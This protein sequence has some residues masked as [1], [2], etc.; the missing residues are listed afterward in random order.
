MLAW[1]L[2]VLVPVQL[3][4]NAS[5][6]RMALV[7]GSEYSHGRPR[8]PR[9]SWLWLAPVLAV[10]AI[11]GVG[12]RTEGR[13]SPS[14]SLCSLAFQINK[15]Y[16]FKNWLGQTFD[17]T[18]NI[19]LGMPMF[20]IGVWAFLLLIQSPAYMQSGSLQVIVHMVESVITYVGDLQEVLCSSWAISFCCMF[21]GNES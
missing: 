11:W 4:T 6:E 8:K 1:V 12:Q 16:V 19:L 10:V 9:G 5:G 20:W 18:V 13:L 21:L 14:P 7:L 3:P 15:I 17:T 2:A